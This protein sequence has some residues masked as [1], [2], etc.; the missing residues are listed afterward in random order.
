MTFAKIQAEHERLWAEHLAAGDKNRSQDFVANAES[1]VDQMVTYSGQASSMEEFEWLR[2]ALE[3][4]R[5]VFATVLRKPKWIAVTMPPV[6]EPAAESGTMMWTAQDLENRV[7]ARANELAKD[8][9][10]RKAAAASATQLL[11]RTPSNPEEEREDYET[12]NVYLACDVLDGVIGIAQLQ[13]SAYPRLETVWLEDVKRLK[14]YFIWLES[15]GK[16]RDDSCWLEACG[17]IQRRLLNRDK[18]GN[19]QEFETI[20]AYFEQICLT[21][22]RFDAKKAHD[23]IEAKARRLWQVA[24]RG[25]EKNWTTATDYVESLYENMVAAVCRQDSEAASTVLGLLDTCEP[26]S[27]R[28]HLMTNAFEVAVAARFVPV[29]LEKAVSQSAGA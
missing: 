1:L 8:R 14:A 4:W 27:D 16:G 29:K 15:G 2:T 23:A 9:A 10:V 18:S 13:P 12:A 5:I 17:D 11:A 26:A 19:L 21:N 6:V 20:R 25:D 28:T 7:L 22:D 3:K 24:D